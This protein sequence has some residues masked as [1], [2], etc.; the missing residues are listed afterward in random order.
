MRGIFLALSPLLVVAGLVHAGTQ[1]YHGEWL[2]ALV[3]FALY[4]VGAFI[5]AGIALV[6]NLAADKIEDKKKGWKR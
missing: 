4:F 5:S 6:I 2:T 1:A 3:T